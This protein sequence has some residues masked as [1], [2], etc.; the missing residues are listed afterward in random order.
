MSKT[1]AVPRVFLFNI[2]P[3]ENERSCALAM[4]AA[5]GFAFVFFVPFSHIYAGPLPGFIP[6]CEAALAVCN[7]ISGILLIAQFVRCGS[8]SILVLGWGYLFNALMVLGHGLTFHGMSEQPRAVDGSDQTS[9]WLYI[10][11]HAGFPVYVLAYTVLRGI[12]AE[13]DAPLLH[14][15]RALAVTAGAT[16]A[17]GTNSYTGATSVVGGTFEVDGSVTA[18]NITVGNGGTLSSTGKVGDPTIQAGGTLAPGSAANPSGTLTIVGPLTFQAGSTY[19]IALTPTA[20]SSTAVTGTTTIGGGTVNVLA[21]AGTYTAARYT[22]LT[23]TGGVTGRFAGLTT[24]S[25]LVFLTPTLAYDANDVYLALT[26]TVVTPPPTPG[27]R[28]RPRWW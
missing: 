22:L 25:N 15:M 2:P 16:K 21:G 1:P 6:G 3:D 24:T 8:A 12:E 5:L 10:F 28:P 11:W 18:S 19:Q 7:L 27:T 23:A 14:P 4:L 9:I 26:R 13:R 20:D 17:L